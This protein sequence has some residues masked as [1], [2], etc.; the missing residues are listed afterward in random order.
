MDGFN[1]FDIR[2]GGT[3]DCWFLSALSAIAERKSLVTR[4]IKPAVNGSDAAK[5]GGLY[6]FQFYN[7]GEWH[8][9]IIDNQIPL[10][11]SARP[12][13]NGQSVKSQR[14]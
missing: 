2:Q 5:E 7:M 6:R 3:G 10:E 8:D 1:P 11:Y 13:F 4:V 9:I 12:G 14:L